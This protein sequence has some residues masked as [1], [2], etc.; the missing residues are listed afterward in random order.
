MINKKEL[1][2]YELCIEIVMDENKKETASFKDAHN[3]IVLMLGKN[4]TFLF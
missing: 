2:L 4:H 1:Q 3:Y